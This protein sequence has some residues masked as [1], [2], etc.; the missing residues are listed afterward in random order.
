MNFP[1]QLV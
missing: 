1:F